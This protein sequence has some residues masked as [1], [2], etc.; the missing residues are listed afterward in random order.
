MSTIREWLQ[1]Q[2]ELRAEKRRRSLAAN[3]DD[4]NSVIQKVMHPTSTR[5]INDLTEPT[6]RD[7]NAK[8]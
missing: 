3:D 4:E 5:S 1:R 6:N 2:R 8:P 7:D